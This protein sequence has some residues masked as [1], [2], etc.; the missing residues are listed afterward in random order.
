MPFDQGFCVEC[1]SL[2]HTVMIIFRPWI[3]FL[4][5]ASNYIKAPPWFL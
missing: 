1:R 3:G 5:I 4:F 2:A